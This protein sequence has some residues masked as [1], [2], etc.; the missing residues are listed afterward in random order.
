MQVKSLNIVVR[1][2]LMDRGYPIHFYLP[3]LHHAL[4]SLE[5]LS[6]DHNFGANVKEVELTITNNRVILPLDCIEV[7]QVFGLYGSERK[8]LLLNDRIT[9]IED[10]YKLDESTLP[11]YVN[12]VSSTI[13]EPT[14][15]NEYPTVYYPDKAVDYDYNVD[16]DKGELILGLRSN[17]DSVFIRYLTSSVSKTTANLIHPYAVPTI[18]SYIDWMV[19]RSDG[20]PQ[21][22]VSLLEAAYYNEKRLLR[23]R[24][25]P[26]SVGE[27][28]EILVKN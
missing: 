9:T 15:A 8:S 7:F 5:K 14:I 28:Y 16:L 27:L 2:S 20:S 11:N 21:S 6:F 25:N 17:L 1:E 13:L 10:T 26:L 4:T 3:F 12:A 19:S 24:L 23:S 18:K 22:K